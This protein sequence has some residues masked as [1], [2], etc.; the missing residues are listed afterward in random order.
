MKRYPFS[1]FFVGFIMNLTMKYAFLF[2][3]SLILMLVGIWVDVCF[4][5]GLALL[6]ADV[7]LSFAYQMYIR[8]EVLKDEDSAFAPFRNAML[9]KNWREN[10]KGIVEQEIKEN[11]DA[12]KSQ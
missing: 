8:N 12:P 3:S 11:N 7:V 5:I 2:F 6:L 1:L 9:D 4:Y 10:I